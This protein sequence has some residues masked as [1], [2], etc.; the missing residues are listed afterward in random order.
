[1]FDFI[2]AVFKYLGLG[3]LALIVLALVFG[4]R[5]KKKWEYEAEFRDAKGREFGEFDIE[6]SRIEKE[7]PNYTLKAE[8]DMRHESLGHLQTVQVY[9]DDLLILEGLVTEAGRVR[10]GSDR[11]Q[12]QISDAPIGRIC[13]IVCD[14]EELFRQEMVRD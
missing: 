13:R 9:L 6:L 4:K 14:G 12:N 11:I 2:L 7:E 5:I 3:L 10:L 1:M 8:F